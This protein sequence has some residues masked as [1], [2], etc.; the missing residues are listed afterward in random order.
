MEI[1]FLGLPKV[2]SVSGAFCVSRK[3]NIFD[4][5]ADLRLFLNKQL[6]ISST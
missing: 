3:I 6:Q 1:L 2:P 5:N 4:Q